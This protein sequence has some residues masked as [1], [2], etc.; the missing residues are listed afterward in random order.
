M[1]PAVLAFVDELGGDI[2]M[3]A[4]HQHFLADVGG[5]LLERPHAKLRELVRHFKVRPGLRTLVR[6]LGRKLGENVDW[7]RNA[8][9][10]WKD[11]SEADHAVPDGNDDGLAV[12]RALAQ[13]VL[14]YAAEGDDV[15][16]PFDRPYLDLYDRCTEARRAVDT[17][18]RCLPKDQRVHRTLRRV[19][20]LLDPVVSEVPFS[21]L[22]RTCAGG[23]A[24]LTSYATHYA[25]FPRP[26]VATR[27]PGHRS[28][29]S[30]PS[31]PKRHC[32]TSARP[33]RPSPPNAPAPPRAWAGQG[34]AP[35]HRRRPQTHPGPWTRPVGAP[36]TPS[37][38]SPCRSETA[39]SS[40]PKV[41]NAV[42]TTPRRAEHHARVGV[43]PETAQPKIDAVGFFACGCESE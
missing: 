8:V 18:L 38:R 7:G 14:D 33:S 9:A 1:T 20:D 6:D 15:G 3:L 39:S 36:L 37:R 29:R 12:V 26:Q 16:L 40:A 25:W 2:P 24:C 13:W 42:S 27:R 35:G 5:D 28:R 21:Q 43:A 23:P 4:C 34:P 17:F 22:A 19:R 41:C 11:Q 10:A 30:R 31:R 32:V